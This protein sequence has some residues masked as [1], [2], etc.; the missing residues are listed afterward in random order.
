MVQGI[1]N[2]K[3]IGLRNLHSPR[4]TVKLWIIDNLEELDHCLTVLGVYV[5]C[6]IVCV[7]VCVCVRVCVC[8]TQGPS[9][10]LDYKLLPSSCLSPCTSQIAVTMLCH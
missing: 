3:I 8:V 5:I 2:N 6:T 1:L 7:C 9:A 4:E 10:Y